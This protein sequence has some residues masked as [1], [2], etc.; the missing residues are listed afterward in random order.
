MPVSNALDD[1][2][3]SCVSNGG[4][5]QGGNL[6][7]ALT[8]TD[9]GDLVMATP[10]HSTPAPRAKETAALRRRMERAVEAL[11]AAL[12]AMDGDPDLEPA[13]GSPE[14]GHGRRRRTAGTLD[15][16]RWSSGDLAAAAD[17]REDVSEDEGGAC[18]G[19]GDYDEKE[20]DLDHMCNWQDE[21]DQTRLQMLATR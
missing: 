7:P 10:S 3:S 5:E 16:R 15:Q 13:L 1:G 8:E 11:L 9:P 14:V 20:P 17:E 4:P 6:A 12:D 19:E 21:G 18:E 2:T